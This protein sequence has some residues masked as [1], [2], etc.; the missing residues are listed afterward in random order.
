MS[1][2]AILKIAFL[3]ITH[4]LIFCFQPNFAVGSRRACLQRPRDK[5]CKF[6][7]SKMADDRHF[8]NR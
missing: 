1:A 5:N 4:Q 3:T 8:E 2:A 6:L 7:K